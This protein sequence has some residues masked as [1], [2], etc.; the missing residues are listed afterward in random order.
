MQ[1]T[2]LP[3][4]LWPV[5]LTPLRGN[6]EVDTHA[7]E[8]LTNFYIESGAKGL[9]TNCLSGEMF[10][11]TEKERLQVISTVF[12]IAAPHKVKV[13]ATGTFSSNMNTCA[14]FIKQVYDAGA[15]A[16]VIIANQLANQEEDE[17]TFKKNTD[18]LLNLTGTIPLGMYECPYPYKRLISPGMMKWLGETGRFFYHKDTSCDPD[19]IKQKIESLKESDCSF[20]NAHTATS[21]FSLEMGGDGISPIG[22]NFYPELY[23]HL[24]NEFNQHGNTPALQKL[25]AQLSIMDGIASQCYPYSAKLFL[26]FRKI[27]LNE[28]CRIPHAH[29]SV[30]KYLNLQALKR[31]FEEMKDEWFN[32]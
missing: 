4:G 10:Q 23:T 24:I 6:N 14:V 13:V 8:A 19:S 29:M 28:T 11:L 18:T 20:Y 25:N 32:C 26:Q 27:K 12:N 1:N 17:T 22:A 15:D 30:E 3:G 5:M 16:V 21:L 2:K 7:L 31:A 9:F